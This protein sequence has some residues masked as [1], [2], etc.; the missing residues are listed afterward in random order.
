MIEF[1]LT[2]QKYLRG[3]LDDPNVVETMAVEPR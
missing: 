1:I 2:K 3:I